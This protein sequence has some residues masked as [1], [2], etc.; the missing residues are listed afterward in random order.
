MEPIFSRVFVSVRG[1]ALILIALAVG[2]ASASAAPIVVTFDNDPTWERNP[3]GF[4]SSDSK[5]IHFSDTVP[6]PDQGQQLF[7]VN[8]PSG[9][10]GDNALAVLTDGD[11]SALLIEFDVLATALSMDLWNDD[12]GSSE[13]GDAAVLTAFLGSDQVGQVSVLLT[14]DG[15]MKQISFEGALFDSATLKYDVDPTIGRTEVVDNVSAALIPEPQAAIVFGVGALLVGTAC[16]R[17][18]RAEVGLRARRR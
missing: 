18:S 7:V 16:R 12:P 15:T 3:T 14:G 1:V 10:A 13:A 17:R 2:A 4:T 6:D 9:T 5:A 8:S 11:D